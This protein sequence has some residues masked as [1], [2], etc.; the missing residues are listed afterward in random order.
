MSKVKLKTN[1][2]LIDNDLADKAF[3]ETAQVYAVYYPQKKALLLAPMEDEFFPKLH[4]AGLLMLKSRNL[5]GDKTVSMYEII[6]DNELDDA[7]RD[8]DYEYTEG[9]K[10]LNVKI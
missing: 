5:K 7:D 2:L 8:L 3:G 10:L 4:K 1:H 9:I 6:I